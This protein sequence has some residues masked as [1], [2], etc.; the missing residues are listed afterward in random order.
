MFYLLVV[1]VAAV[2][3]L[4]QSAEA[5]IGPGA[6]F[7]LLSSFLVVFTTILI[8][9]LSLLIWPFR[10]AWRFLRR[11]SQT[12]PWVKRLI[13]VGFDGQDPKL[14]E[15][16]M[17]QGLL[18]NMKKLAAAG[19]YKKLGTTYPSISPVAWSSFATGTNP[20]RHNIFDFL[21]RDRKTYLPLLS[22]THI[23][24][25]ERTLKIGPYRIPLNKPEVRLLRKSKPF[26][27][28]LG[29][30][31]I[32]STVLRVP[33]TFPPDKFYGAQLS[34]MCVPDLLG[35]QGTFLFYTTRPSE[36]TF[37]EG[38]L[39]FQ[40]EQNSDRME[41]TLQGPENLFRDGNPPLEVPLK[42]ELDRAGNKAIVDLDGERVELTPMKL[43]EWIPLS[44]P[45]APAIKVSGLCRLMVTELDEHFSLY[46]T[47]IN[48][49]PEKPAMP[50]SHPS[51]YATYLSKKI[52]HFCTLGLAE[53]TWALNEGVT[54]DGTF[55]QQTYDIDR[56]RQDMFFSSLDRLRRGSLVC[57]FDAT[58]RIQHMFWH[59]LEKDHPA[60]KGT[61]IEKAEH[62]KAI[63]G[64]YKHNDALVGK[65]MDELGEGD[66]LLV[67]SDHGFSSFQRGVNL[68]GWLK[69]NGFLTLKPGADGTSEWL[70]DVDWSK[71]KAYSLG[72]TGM[73]LN[74]KGRE[75]NGI[76]E[77]GQE[78]K[79]VKDAIIEKLGGLRD[80]QRNKVGIKEVFD[81]KVVYEGPYSENAPDLI[82]GYDNGY[83]ISWDCASGMVA[84]PVFEDNEK[85]WSGDHCVDP[86]LV[87][88]VLFSNVSI[89]EDREPTLMDIAPSALEMFGLTPPRHMEGASLFT[90]ASFQKS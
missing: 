41:T 86:R 52:G 30:H 84:G 8:A 10:M 22:S 54:D 38:G 16:F 88:G 24:S 25:V 36:G 14:T 85:A 34:A 6:G 76:V 35:T 72:L 43:S 45:A 59:Y 47:P 15:K 75:A 40:L 80:D 66:V 21:D 48:I 27:S 61:D 11:K 29:E 46:V 73:F 87:P 67:L 79:D 32:W 5:Y 90:K 56:E 55:L 74:M 62:R 50:I 28:I 19:S 58:D 18:P 20:A 4:P 49:D 89:P 33:I 13:V 9:M 60:N 44:F 23:G 26:W 64:I 31:N 53:D 68:N 42:I 7:A 77:P 51:Y 78:E 83:R 65:V 2:L 17:K 39:R 63:E 3:L 57:V 70:Q 69:D 82:I 81:T 12:P 37:K 1:A 71:T